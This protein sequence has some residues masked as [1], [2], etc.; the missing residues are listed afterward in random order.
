MSGP[1][2][3]LHQLVDCLHQISRIYTYDA[4]QYLYEFMT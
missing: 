3:G 1:L 4:Q 2:S